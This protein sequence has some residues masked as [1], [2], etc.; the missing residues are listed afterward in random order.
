MEL[1]E[2]IV[3]SEAKDDIS[4][5]AEYIAICIAGIVNAVSFSA[6]L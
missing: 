4:N 3:L 2:V 1:Y 6:L 5:I